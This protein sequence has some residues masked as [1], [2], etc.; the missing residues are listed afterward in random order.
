[1]MPVFNGSL[2]NTIA[3]FLA[4]I[5]LTVRSGDICG[6]MFVPGIQINYGALLIDEAQLSYPGD[7]LHEAGHLAVMPPDRRQRTHIDVGKKAAEE[8][9]TI[10]WSYAALVHLELDSAVVFHPDGYRGGSQALIDNFCEGRYIGVPWLQWLG[11]TVDEK[12]GQ[13]LGLAPYPTMLKW[14]RDSEQHASQS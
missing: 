4:E 11:M 1:M 5:G 7:I 2:T 12:R 6:Q 10:A 3:M 13:E 9:A 14:L 8:I